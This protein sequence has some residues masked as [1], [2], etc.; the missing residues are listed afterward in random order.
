ML[1]KLIYPEKLQKSA[2]NQ[3]LKSIKLLKMI[4]N[5]KLQIIYCIIYAAIFYMIFIPLAC[6]CYEPVQSVTITKEDIINA[7]PT[8]ERVSFSA[9]DLKMIEMMEKRHFPRTYPEFDDAERLKNLEWELLGKVWIYSD[10]KDRIN[11]L[12]L[13]SS[14]TM[15]SGVALPARIS[16]KRNVKRMRND[17]IQLRKRDNVGLIDGFLRLINPEL[18]EQY[19]HHADRQFEL[20]Y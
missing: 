15:L 18:Y 10:Q 16:S 7:K 3:G 8:P 5:V 2:L 4:K 14:N 19:R 11:K 17:E 13:A 1:Q 9:K 6:Y 12:K 20:E